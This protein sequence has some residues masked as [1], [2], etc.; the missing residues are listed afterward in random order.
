MTVESFCG[1]F[2][3]VL[4]IFNFNFISIFQST[5]SFFSFVRMTNRGNGNAN[6]KLI[7][8]LLFFTDQSVDML[9][10]FSV[11]HVLHDVLLLFGLLTLTLLRGFG[12]RL[13][14]GTR[15]LTKPERD[16]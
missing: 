8:L 16:S 2:I 3:Q 15:L 4:H 10:W 1:Q 14:T 6:K 7:L 5:I 11:L 9:D 13:C 12:L